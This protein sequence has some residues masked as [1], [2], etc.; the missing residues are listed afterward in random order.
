MNQVTKEEFIELYKKK[1]INELSELLKVSRQ[2]IHK[3][4]LKFNL[5][6]K[7]KSLIKKK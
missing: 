4:A 1:S 7:R 5:S 6:P 3:W 2:T